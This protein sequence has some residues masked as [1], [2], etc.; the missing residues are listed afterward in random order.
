MC[1]RLCALSCESYGIRN[2]PDNLVSAGTYFVILSMVWGWFIVLP[3]WDI[4]ISLV[5]LDSPNT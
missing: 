5:L 1:L 2:V 3:K 4:Y